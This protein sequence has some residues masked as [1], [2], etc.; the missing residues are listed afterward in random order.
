MVVASTR[1]RRLKFLLIEITGFFETGHLEMTRGGSVVPGAPPR[2][3]F[4]F[5]RERLEF[6]LL[7]VLLDV[8]GM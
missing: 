6:R 3:L 5:L 7:F 4:L 1:N 2:D 8:F